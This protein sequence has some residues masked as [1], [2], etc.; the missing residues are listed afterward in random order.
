MAR[1]A[2]YEVSALNS[3]YVLLKDL[4][5]W[6]KYPTITNSAEEVV[7]EVMV[8]LMPNQRIFYYDS[9]GILTELIHK[10]GMFHSFLDVERLP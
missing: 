4:G 3:K 2:K 1:I 10:D 7:S 6:D 9:N 8:W 5:P